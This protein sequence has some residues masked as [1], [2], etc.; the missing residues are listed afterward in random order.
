M[1]LENYKD[2]FE[3][4]G[5][6]GERYAVYKIDPA[7]NELAKTD[8][9]QW[10]TVW[11]DG[12]LLD[13][14]GKQHIEAIVNNFDFQY[15][16][17]FFFDPEKVKGRSYRP[18]H[19]P[20]A[21]E[22]PVTMEASASAK[23]NAAD[24]SVLFFEDFSTTLVGR[25]P[26][27]WKVGRTTGTVVNLDGLPGNWAVMAGDAS[28]APKQIQAL[29]RDFT[30]T[31]ELVASQNFTWGAKGFTLLLAN[32]PSPG[33]AD[34][35]IRL[36]LRPGF[37]G[38]DGE[39]ELETKFAAGYQSGTKWYPATGFSNNQKNNH[40]TVSIRKSGESV[41]V[42]ID[43]NKIAEYDKAMPAAQAFNSMRFFVL[44]NASELNDKFYISRIKVTKQ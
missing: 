30:L 35:Y 33:N 44:G 2:V 15:A 23:S 20:S 43:S 18:L 25:T 37:D 34:S 3:G 1:L 8:K 12:D 27:A 28:L 5:G 19:S 4:G 40:I 17:D 21:V 7:M 13:P 31:Y 10:I 32:E 42:F 6:P 9:P 38:K 22:A 14:V 29:S 41:R 39:A 26:S 24:A 11:W 36:K 16:H